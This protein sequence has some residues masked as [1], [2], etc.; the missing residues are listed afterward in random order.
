[1]NEITK[2][3]DKYFRINNPSDAVIQFAKTLIGGNWAAIRTGHIVVHNNYRKQFDSLVKK[4]QYAQEIVSF[5]MSEMSRP[6]VDAWAWGNLNK[7]AAAQALVDAYDHN[8]AS[9]WSKEVFAA[10][11]SGI[12]REALE[13]MLV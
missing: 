1:M 11:K 2:V 10:L 4:E 12:T 7:A 3:N 8:Q 9:D 5:D 13:K 6:Q